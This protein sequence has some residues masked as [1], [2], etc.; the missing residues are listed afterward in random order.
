MKDSLGYCS[1]LAGSCWS[2]QVQYLEWLIW[3]RPNTPAVKNKILFFSAQTPVLLF[4]GNFT[5][6]N[7]QP[8]ESGI[9]LPKQIAMSFLTF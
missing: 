7:P 8:F 4:F 2:Q 5:I 3:R 6:L 9:A 1:L